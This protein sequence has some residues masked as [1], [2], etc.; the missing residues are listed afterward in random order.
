MTAD[1]TPRPRGRLSAEEKVARAA[2]RIID[3]LGEDTIG[4]VREAQADVKGCGGVHFI[5]NGRLIALAD[6]V[7]AWRGVSR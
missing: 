7:E 5:T 6:A 1:N 4:E 3:S 2:A